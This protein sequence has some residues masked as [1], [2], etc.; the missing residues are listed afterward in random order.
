MHGSEG[1]DALHSTLEEDPR[2]KLLPRVLGSL[3][4][5]GLMVGLMI[6]R[7]TTPDPVELLQV[8]P[9]ADGVLVWF[10]REPKLH[11]EQVDG[12]VALL[13]DAQ[14]KAAGGQ[15]KVN[16]KDVNWRIRKTDAGLLLNLVA[17]RPLRG[18]WSGEKAEG[19]WRLEI[20]LQEQ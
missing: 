19:R 10:N 7:L 14:G 15:L 9:A 2:P 13:F 6:G 11:G 8:E 4:I 3:A 1:K 12:A 5:V 18:E 20:H 16:G 17:A